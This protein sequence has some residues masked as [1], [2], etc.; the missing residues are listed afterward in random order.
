MVR[1]GLQ[2]LTPPD[3]YYTRSAS[4]EP[5][6]SPLRGAL[7]ADTCVVGAGLAGLSTA[8]ELARRGRPTFDTLVVAK[9]FSASHAPA[10]TAFTKVMEQATEDY[11]KA[12]QTWTSTSPQVT[13]K[14]FASNFTPPTPSNLTTAVSDMQLAFTD[15]AGRPASV[16]G[17]GG[18]NI[19]GMTLKAGV[20]KWGTGLLIPTNVTLSGN[21]T[22]VWILQIAKSLSVSNATEVSLTGGALSKNVFWQVSGEVTLGTTAHLEGVILGQT[23]ISLKTGA[24]INGRLLAQTA[25]SIESSVVV[26]PAP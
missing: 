5:E 1:Q 22:D 2:P 25:V 24:S 26:E 23:A 14:V 17:L 9:A 6:R 19:G 21:A 18:G 11:V 7:E 16:T 4:A 3:S 8:L 20:Y 13:G 12:P 15:A 10:L